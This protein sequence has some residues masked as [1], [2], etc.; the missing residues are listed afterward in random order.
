MQRT[1][2]QTA[3]VRFTWFRPHGLDNEF[4]DYSFNGFRWTKVAG[5][6]PDDATEELLSVYARVDT[7][8]SLEYCVE[9]T[10][11]ALANDI[12]AEVIAIPDEKVVEKLDRSNPN[13]IHEFPRDVRRPPPAALT[14]L[15][16]FT[17]WPADVEE[18]ETYDAW[19]AL[20]APWELST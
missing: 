7:Q 8:Y 17:P 5:I 4:T 20:Y 15:H 19:A 2:D 14:D 6:E 9:A 3:V 13:V 12:G 11:Y 1:T 10:A 18:P 16:Q